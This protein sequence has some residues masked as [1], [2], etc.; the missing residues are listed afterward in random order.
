MS[1]PTDDA[2]ALEIAQDVC[3]QLPVRLKGDEPVIEFARRLLAWE[4]SK[5]RSA[6]VRVLREQHA[7]LQSCR[8]GLWAHFKCGDKNFSYNLDC[9]EMAKPFC[10][11]YRAMLSAAPPAPSEDA[12]DAQPTIPKHIA[13]HEFVDDGKNA[14]AICGDDWLDTRHRKSIQPV[15]CKGKNC[16]HTNKNAQLVAD[17]KAIRN[18]AI[19]EGMKLV[20][21]DEINAALAAE[22]KEKP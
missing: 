12:K 17:L 21:I 1:G 10:N 3:K 2:K 7:T 16:G 5:D 20:S 14:C 13:A 15:P 19:A 4:R 18:R 9:D 11:A 6:T 8:D 22:R